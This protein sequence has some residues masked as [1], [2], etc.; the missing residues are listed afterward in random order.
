ML[1]TSRDTVDRLISEKDF[2]STV[3]EFAQAHGWKVAHFRPGMT[4]RRVGRDGKPVWVTP[5]QG[6]GKGFPDLVLVRKQVLLFVELK[7]QKGRVSKEQLAWLDALGSTCVRA[8]C[9]RPSY[10]EKIERILGSTS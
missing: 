9:W 4:G 5:V 1:K 6:D 2:L 7:S 3:I 8:Y 10:W